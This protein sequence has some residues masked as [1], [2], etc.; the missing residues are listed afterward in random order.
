MH[1]ALHG[2]EHHWF[3]KLEENEYQADIIKA[4]DVFDGI[5]D[6]N[7]WV[8]CY[9]YGAT[10]DSLLNYCKSINCVAGFTVE[11]RIADL[12]NE[13]PLLI[14]RFDTNDYPPRKCD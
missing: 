2:Y 10:Q 13:N 5:I 8:F 3:N 9:P 12:K 4:L 14:P 1:F 11:P 7:N 6:R